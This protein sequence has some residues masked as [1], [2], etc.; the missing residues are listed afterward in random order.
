MQFTLWGIQ[1]NPWTSRTYNLSFIWH[2]T[3]F[4]NDFYQ[5]RWIYKRLHQEQDSFIKEVKLEKHLTNKV[6]TSWTTTHHQPC[7]SP[8]KKKFYSVFWTTVT[9]LCDQVWPADLW[10]ESG[11]ETSALPHGFATDRRRENEFSGSLIF[12]VFATVQ[13]STVMRASGFTFT[14]H[15]AA[16]AM[17]R[18]TGPLDIISRN[19]MPNFCW[20]GKSL[21][22]VFHRS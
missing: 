3:T 6:K 4:I 7:Q 17:M 16:N 15:P 19:P 11:L 9:Q 1:L 13:T 18:Q 5:Q 12:N 21:L 14:T 8:T 10:L 22:S 20:W 2:H